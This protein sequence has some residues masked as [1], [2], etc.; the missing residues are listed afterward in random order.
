MKRRGAR[1]VA[2][3]AVA[4]AAL[5]ASAIGQAATIDLGTINGP[6]ARRVGNSG[7]LGPF[8]DSFTFTIGAGHSLS[9]SAYVTTG[10]N[11]RNQ[12]IDMDGVLLG[13]GGSVLEEGDAV[14]EY[15][16]EGWPSRNVTFGSI[17]LG[18]GD[19]VLRMTGTSLSV[20]PD[21]PIW[22]GYD[23]TVTFAAVAAPVPEPGTWA[24]MAAGLA[25]MG[26]A[27]RRTPA[28]SET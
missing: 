10:F 14:T 19:Y 3:L 6:I 7:L 16:P 9:W 18:P 12:I 8:E 23:G 5:M 1:R 21:I 11:R 2:M 25:V 20:Y 13:S 27:R 24:L 4:T 22:G 15:A 28:R 17:T 26:L